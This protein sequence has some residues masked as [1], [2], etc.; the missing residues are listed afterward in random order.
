MI[1]EMYNVGGNAGKRLVRMELPI[2]YVWK[3][4]V[5]FTCGSTTVISAEPGLY[6][7]PP[8]GAQNADITDDPACFRLQAAIQS[9]IPGTGIGFMQGADVTIQNLS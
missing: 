1:H 7:E 9:P 4:S 5:R 6:G 8:H 2:E 3:N